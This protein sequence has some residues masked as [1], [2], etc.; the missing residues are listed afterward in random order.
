M[1]QDWQ[2]FKCDGCGRLYKFCKDDAGLNDYWLDCYAIENRKNGTEIELC[3][4]KCLQN[5]ITEIIDQGRLD[6][7]I[8][9]FLL[10]VNGESSETTAKEDE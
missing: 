1:R 6:I 3:S 2:Y 10:A 5:S 4:K 8:S 9:S 7:N